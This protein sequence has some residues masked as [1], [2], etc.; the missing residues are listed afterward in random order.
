[1]STEFQAVQEIWQIYQ[2]R[3]FAPKLNRGDFFYYGHI[4]YSA[5]A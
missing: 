1:M 4:A 3:V 5:L 2:K